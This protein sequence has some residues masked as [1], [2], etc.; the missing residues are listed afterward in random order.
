[1][2][3]GFKALND[4]ELKERYKYVLYF[5]LI[6]AS[7]Y[8][9]YEQLIY[10]PPG[11]GFDKSEDYN[12]LLK[13][14]ND[15]ADTLLFLKSYITQND[16]RDAKVI[17]S[18]YQIRTEFPYLKTLYNRGKQFNG[19]EKDW[20]LYAIFYPE[21]Y[22]GDEYGFKDVDY[23]KVNQLLEESDYKLLI[24]SK[25]KIIYE[26]DVYL[27]LTYKIEEVFIPLYDNDSYTVYEIH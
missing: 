24:L 1:M 2:F 20:D 5:V 12:E 23:N 7:F 21:D 27:P 10:H 15:T 11:E 22:Y 3:I 14:D 26:N 25:N 6:F 8:I 17:S 18:I 19:V 9:G 4:I 13:M 16:I